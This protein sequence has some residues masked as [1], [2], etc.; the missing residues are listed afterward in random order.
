MHVQSQ[1]RLTWKQKEPTS[2]RRRNTDHTKENTGNECATLGGFYCKQHIV[3]NH[4]GD[5]LQD[6]S[7]DGNLDLLC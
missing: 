2:Y 7:G 3:T 6:W 1:G 4:S 5:R